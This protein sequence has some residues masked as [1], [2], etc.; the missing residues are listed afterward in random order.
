MKTRVQ[1]WGNSLALRIPKSFATEVGLQTDSSVE[2]S[3]V[4]GK[5]VITPIVK[6]KLTL[7]ALLA[8]VTDNNLHREVD[9]GSAVGSEAW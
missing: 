1:K 9:T 4:K 6:R 3:L 2:V 7:R 5:L 8:Q